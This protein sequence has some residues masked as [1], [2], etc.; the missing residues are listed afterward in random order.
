MIKLIPCL[1]LCLRKYTKLTWKKINYIL[2]NYIWIIVCGNV[3][4]R[5]NIDSHLS[6]F[7]IADD[8]EDNNNNNQVPGTS[9][10]TQDD[11]SANKDGPGKSTDNIEPGDNEEEKDGS[12]RSGRYNTRGA[13][14]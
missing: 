14:K 13:K 8:T 7:V 10:D 5:C 6:F 1:R 3:Q 4:C 12:S 11:N 2:L 9:K